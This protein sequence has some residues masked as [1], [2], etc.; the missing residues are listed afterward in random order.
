MNSV[1]LEFP[2]QKSKS[3]FMKMEKIF[4]V[5]KIWKSNTDIKW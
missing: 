4:S 5:K 2:A 3:V 1:V